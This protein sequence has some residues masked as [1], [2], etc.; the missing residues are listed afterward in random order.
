MNKEIVSIEIKNKSNGIYNVD[1][2]IA[3]TFKIYRN[4]K[5][6]H[7]Q[8]NGVTEK[9]VKKY[10]YKA[11]AEIINKFF[12]ALIS[13]FKI[14]NWKADYSVEVCD[15]WS[16]SIKITY[17]DNSTKKVVGTVDLPPMGKQL[18]EEIFKLHDFDVKP[19]IL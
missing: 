13:V 3:E 19:W 5:I 2:I 14:Q 18:K 11:N 16:W 8:Y 4:G 6:K 9:P 15:G 12:E 7:M 10:H 17:I 1:E